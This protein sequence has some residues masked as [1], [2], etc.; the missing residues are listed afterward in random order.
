[1]KAIIKVG[2]ANESKKALLVSF[3]T[4]GN[5]KGFKNAEKYH[6][7]TVWI[8]KS[9]V[10]ILEEKEEMTSYTFYSNLR[11]RNGLITDGKAHK[12]RLKRTLKIEIPKWL[13]KD[14]MC[15]GFDIV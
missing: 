4:S 1:L 13:Y 12:V 10:N 7:Q 11:T 14:K 6:T 15:Y 5:Y 8:P 3:W 2:I 9:Q